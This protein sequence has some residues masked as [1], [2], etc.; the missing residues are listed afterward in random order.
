[1]NNQPRAHAKNP[2]EFVAPASNMS[3]RRRL[4]ALAEED[5]YLTNQPR[6]AS[7]WQHP[8]LRSIQAK[9]ER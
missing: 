5:C 3:D 6:R 1:M 7:R 2:I 4:L 8:L 9:L